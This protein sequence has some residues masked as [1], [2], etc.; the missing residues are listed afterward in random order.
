MIHEKIL[1]FPCS[2][3]SFVLLSMMSNVHRMI[4]N[5]RYL[6]LCSFFPGVSICAVPHPGTGGE[7]ITVCNLDG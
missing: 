2:N 5:I 4:S 7:G 3:A 6:Y 1:L